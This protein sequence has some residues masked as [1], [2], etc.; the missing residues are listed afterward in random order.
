M[1]S[2]TCE[3][4]IQAIYI[5]CPASVN[6]QQSYDAPTD[7]FVLIDNQQWLRIFLTP[8]EYITLR[9]GEPPRYSR[10]FITPFYPLKL[11]EAGFVVTLAEDNDKLRDILEEIIEASI[12]TNKQEHTA[13][14]VLDYVKPD[15]ADKKR[16][17]ANK[18][19]PF[20][21]RKGMI[22]LEP[23]NGTSGFGADRYTVN[24]MRF[25]FRQI[26]MVVV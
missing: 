13:I 11:R 20:T 14:Q 26:T 19:E 7:W 3:T 17:I 6:L 23:G 8:E 18:T 25:T 9:E 4:N 15:K 1:T 16:A 2:H 24:G 12:S 10:S 5:K 22:T 21:T